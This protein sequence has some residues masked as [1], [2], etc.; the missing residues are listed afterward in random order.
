MSLYRKNWK[1]IAEQHEKKYKNLMENHRLLGIITILLM[2]MLIMN[3]T[4]L[5]YYLS[6]KINQDIDP[7]V[8]NVMTNFS[9]I[10]N[11]VQEETRAFGATVKVKGLTVG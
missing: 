3:S 10:N 11:Q 8:E 7:M 4:T 5:S 9:K 2:L 6:T 1:W